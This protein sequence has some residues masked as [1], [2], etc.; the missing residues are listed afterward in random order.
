MSDIKLKFVFLAVLVFAA[1]IFILAALVPSDLRSGYFYAAAFLTALSVAYLFIIPTCPGK[2]GM[3][4]A[5]A[6]LGIGIFF[7]V[8]LAA[9]AA[10][11]LVFSLCGFLKLSLATDALWVLALGCH[12]VFSN[13]TMNQVSK[14]AQETNAFPWNKQ[15]ASEIRTI[16]AKAKD[17]EDRKILERLIDAASFSNPKQYPASESLEKQIVA[18]VGELESSLGDAKALNDQAQVLFRLFNQRNILVKNEFNKG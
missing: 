9:V 4:S 14:L 1:V 18:A 17:D 16:Q 10:L 8:L 7:G 2:K 15:V 13:V 5:L 3:D 12:F 11:S 6:G